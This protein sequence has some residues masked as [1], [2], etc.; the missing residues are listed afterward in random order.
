MFINNKW[1]LFFLVVVHVGIFINP[2]PVAFYAYPSF[3]PRPQGCGKLVAL[4]APLAASA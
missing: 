2:V 1:L 4:P 3:V